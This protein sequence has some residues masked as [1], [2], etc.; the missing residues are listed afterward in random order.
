MDKRGWK[1][2]YLSQ[3]LLNQNLR[4]PG[5]A[6]ESGVIT[7]LIEALIQHGIGIETLPCLERVGW[8]GV[9][10]KTFYKYFPI[11]SKNIGSIK[12]P[13]IKL[14]LRIWIMNYK[15]VCKKEAKKVISQLKDYINSGYSILGMITTNDS[16]TCGFT[17]TMNLLELSSKYKELGIK[18]EIFENPS[19]ENMKNI[20]PNLCE[21]GSG[22]FTAELNKQINKNKLDIKMVGYDIWNNSSEEIKKVIKN[23]GIII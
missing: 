22:Y 6:V 3:C 17:K 15:K 4:F 23:V 19:L 12:F 8:G 10:R 2:V 7:E 20:I 21:D 11:V 1:I 18:D 13:L 16:P 14:I 9:K 5:I